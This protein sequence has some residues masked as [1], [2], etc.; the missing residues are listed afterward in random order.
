MARALDR[1]KQFLAFHYGS[2]DRMTIDQ[3][4]KQL[5]SMRNPEDPSQRFDV[6]EVWGY[7]YKGRYRMRFIYYNSRAVGC[8]LMGEEILEYARL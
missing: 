4:V 2:N 7:I 8:V 6:L 3:A 5:P 1:A